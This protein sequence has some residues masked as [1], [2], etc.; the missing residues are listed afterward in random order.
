[1]ITLNEKR[2]SLEILRIIAICMVIFN[3]TGGNGF[4][5]FRTA[6]GT[7][8]WYFVILLDVVS[9]A[10]VPLFFMISGVLLLGKDETLKELL[11]KRILRYVVIIVFFSFIYY[12][13]LYIQHPEYGFSI[14]FFITYIYSTPFITPYWFLYSY[15]S[16][17]VL[18]PVLRAIVKN[19]RENEYLWILGFS[20]LLWMAPIWEEIFNLEPINISNGLNASFVIFPILGYGIA[21]VISDKYYNLR[22][23]VVLIIAFILNWLCSVYMNIVEFNESGEL[24]G[25]NL[26]QFAW[27]P[28]IIIF[29][30]FI[31]CFDKRNISISERTIRVIS[32][33]GGGVLCTYLFEDML[34]SDIFLKLFGIVSGNAA[35]L[36]MCIPYTLCIIICGV[37]LSTLLKKIPVINK[38]K[39]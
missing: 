16:F 31:Y 23:R 25:S 34:R 8:L 19:L 17:L 38:L 3:H 36:L 28:A 12:I 26:D 13:R 7:P 39:L 27:L 32:I 22:S 4:E 6:Y 35:R 20:I 33:V 2:I 30:L 1:M 9:K 15:L 5:M 24:S 10:G 14:K 11:L 29:Y 18:L 37:I 21:N